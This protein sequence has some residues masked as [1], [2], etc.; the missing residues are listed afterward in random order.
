M[1]NITQTQAEEIRLRITD[2]SHEARGVGRLADG[3]VVFVAGALPDEEVTARITRRAKGVA[4]AT[5]LQC[6]SPSPERVSPPC[7]LFGRCGGCAAQHRCHEGTLAWK[8]Q[9]AVQAM[10]RIGGVAEGTYRVHDIVPTGPWRTRNKAE[11]RMAG[12][13]LGF[14]AAKSHDVIDAPDCLLQHPEIVRLAQVV[15]ER[16]GR[17]KT[18]APG[19]VIIRVTR[20]GIGW[21]SGGLLGQKNMPLE[22]ELDGMRYQLEP[23]AFWQVNHEGLDAMLRLVLGF[24]NLTGSERVL[25]AYCGVGAFTLPLAKRA[26]SALGIEWYGPAVVSATANAALNGVGNAHFVSAKTED[27]LAKHGDERFDMIVLDPPRTG[28]HPDTLTGMANSGAARIVYVSCDPATLARDVSL[29][30]GFGY[31]LDELACVDMFPWTAH[32]ETV[33]LLTK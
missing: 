28:C 8:Q 25:D 30:R 19:E 32:V 9:R 24:A 2:W 16:I 17:K 31:R 10:A 18:A 14:F 12:D 23:G 21:V 27:Y 5:M 22:E 13:K 33:A 11:Y 15:R 3:R 4:E 20:A 26:A 29:L 6:L 7:P 1:A